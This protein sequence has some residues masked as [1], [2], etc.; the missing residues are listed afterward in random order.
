MKEKIANEYSQIRRL[1]RRSQLE[2]R[3]TIDIDR[4]HHDQIERL[5]LALGANVLCS[6][7]LILLFWLPVD[8]V[9][10]TLEV[11]AAMSAPLFLQALYHERRFKWI[12]A[13]AAALVAYPLVLLGAWLLARTPSLTPSVSGEARAASV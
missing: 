3:I 4:D 5:Y 11:P 1:T 13:F 9:V 2:S 6:S 12:G 10:I 8:L 7:L